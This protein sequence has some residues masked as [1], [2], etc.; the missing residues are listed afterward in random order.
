M[1]P[2]SSGRTFWVLIAILVGSLASGTP[3]AQNPGTAPPAKDPQAE[4]KSL[5]EQV[6][7]LDPKAPDYGA[8][9]KTILEGLIRVNQQLAAENSALRERLAGGNAGTT[10]AP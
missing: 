3:W 9:V 6:A 2:H 8:R 1:S 10:R 4:L 5:T 7:H